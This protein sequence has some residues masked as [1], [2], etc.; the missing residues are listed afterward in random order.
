MKSSII[1]LIISLLCVGCSDRHSRLLDRAEL[2]T[3]TDP[4]SACALLDSMPAPASGELR[5][6]HA[7]LTTGAQYYAARCPETDSII[8]IA[9]DYYDTRTDSPRRML[10]YYYQGL[11][12]IKAR[13]YGNAVV[14]LL[15]AEHT[16]RILNDHKYLGLIYRAIADSFDDVN[17]NSSALDYYKKSY[18]EFCIAD[19]TIYRDYALCDLSR[20]YCNAFKYDEGLVV[21]DSTILRAEAS[22]DIQLKV[23]GL[24]CKGKAYK[25]LNKFE[26]AKKT[27]LDL[28]EIGNEY[29][30]DADW[31]DLG[32][33]YLS[34]NDLDN[35]IIIL[36]SVKKYYPG[37]ASLNYAICKKTRNV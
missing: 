35:A 1:I 20:G 5:A 11:V 34:T 31:L 37:D 18:E 32:L 30:R 9:V 6:R 7:L 8:R 13:D 21:A 4:D 3:F 12:L 26:Q 25:G 22:G 10:S 36:D 2:L 24:R 27:F 16:A 15:N 29:M 19:S 14:S 17:D 23:D 28:K 33:L